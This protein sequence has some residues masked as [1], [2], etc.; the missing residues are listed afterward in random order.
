MADLLSSNRMV[1]LGDRA[2]SLASR[3]M[4]LVAGNLANLDTPNYKAR[5]FDFEKVLR[6]EI[7]AAG[8]QTVPMARTHP[9][10]LRRTGPGNPGP[11][12]DGTGGPGRN[13]GNDVNLDRETM[14][15]ARTQASY[16]LAATLV[17]IEVRRTLGAIRE[18]A[19]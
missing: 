18:A 17:Q 12:S 8:G 13:D 1:Q 6:E 5:G 7:G 10:H 16:Q 4:A 11:T 15:L 2:M 3:R 14:V 19:R 9:A